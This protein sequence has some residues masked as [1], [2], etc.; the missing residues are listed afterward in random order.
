VT[1]IG[2]RYLLPKHGLEKR[3]T[4]MDPYI[5]FDCE[6]YKSNRADEYW[7]NKV[8]KAKSNLVDPVKIAKDI[9]DKRDAG[10]AKSAL[11]PITGRVTCLGLSYN[12][13]FQFFINENERELL[14]D[15]NTFIEGKEVKHYAHYNGDE[16]DVPFLR[17]RNMANNIPVPNWLHY[18]TRHIDIMK[19]FG[20]RNMTALKDLE[21]AL[22]I[23]RDTNKDGAH[24][25]TLWENKD[26]KTLENYCLDD[27]RS[28][29]AI[30]LMMGGGGL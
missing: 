14:I 13:D 23:R 19:M 16:F 29:E 6:T 25:L 9:A 12:G 27:V 7:A 4:N 1:Q 15:I 22:N 20:Y 28:T 3:K 21:F 17:I 18:R 30:Y 11:S 26:Y 10:I 5:V 2:K 8:I 24:A